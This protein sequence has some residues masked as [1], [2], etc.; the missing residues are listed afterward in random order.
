MKERITDS[1]FTLDGV[2]KS[3][4]HRGAMHHILGPLCLTFSQGTT[5]G[6]QG[7][8]GCGKST[9]L[10][11]LAGL[12]KPSKGTVF[13][14]DRAI[15]QMALSEHSAFLQHHVGLLFQ[16][17][18]LLRE[19][20]VV[21]NSMVPGLIAGYPRA[22]CE[23]RAEELIE[24]VGLASKKSAMPATLSG[25]Q[26]QRVALVRALFNKPAFLIADEPTG[27]LDAVTALNIIALITTLQKEEGMGVILATHDPR[28]MAAMEQC[29]TL[30][31]GRLEKV[32]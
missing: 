20:T 26:Q 1:F 28:L 3:F 10:Y 7:T 12:E 2:E 8:S 4:S 13:F 23:R 25:G 16:Q 15:D 31:A 22:Y 29:Y 9:L 32:A 27:N 6:I 19:L 21:E 17:P 5:Y 14:N 30:A 11:L 24:R 18:Y